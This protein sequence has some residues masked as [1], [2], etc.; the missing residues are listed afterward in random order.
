MSSRESH[1]GSSHSC[2]SPSTLTG[3]HFLQHP[4]CGQGLVVLGVSSSAWEVYSL[5]TQRQWLDYPKYHSGN[6]ICLCHLQVCE[7]LGNCALNDEIL[8]FFRDAIYSLILLVLASSGRVCSK[9]MPGI[10]IGP[11][12][13]LDWGVPGWGRPG[14]VRF[15]EDA[16]WENGKVPTGTKNALRHKYHILHIRLLIQQIFIDWLVESHGAWHC[17]GRVEMNRKNYANKCIITEW[18]LRRKGTFYECVTKETGDWVSGG[19]C[20]LELR[21]T[22]VLPKFLCIWISWGSF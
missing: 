14:W 21:A 19:K 8:G 11:V 6:R 13:G 1:S 20:C 9:A 22:V 4:L 10:E 12:R 17:W 3:T 18:E 15:R 7:M 2:C 5:P 16:G